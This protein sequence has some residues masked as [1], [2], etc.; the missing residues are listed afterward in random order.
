[1]WE[2]DESIISVFNILFESFYLDFIHF[3]FLSRTILLKLQVILFQEQIFERLHLGAKERLFGADSGQKY[4]D[5]MQKYR[6]NLCHEDTA[7]AWE[8]FKSIYPTERLAR[9]V[10]PVARP[11]ATS[12]LLLLLL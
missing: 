12:F 4:E 7:R 9:P 11:C 1:V 8:E 10:P 2:F 6:H 3:Y 5:Y